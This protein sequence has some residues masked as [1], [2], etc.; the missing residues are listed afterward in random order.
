ML[1][2]SASDSQGMYIPL[3]DLIGFSGE[4]ANYLVAEAAYKAMITE[5]MKG[6][7]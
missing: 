1:E 6:G 2:S 3:C 5:A 4:N 7:K